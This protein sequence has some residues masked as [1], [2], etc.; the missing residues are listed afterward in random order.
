MMETITLSQALECAEQLR[1]GIGDPETLTGWIEELDGKIAA[2]LL[3][4]D[5]PVYRY[6]ESCGTALLVPKPYHVVYGLYLIA[7]QDLR[8]RDTERY[9]NDAAL[10][11]QALQEWKAYYRRTHVP[12]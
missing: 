7:M 2:E 6:P 11:R 8:D 3:K 4:T 5:P 1:P 9:D 12:G 10:Y